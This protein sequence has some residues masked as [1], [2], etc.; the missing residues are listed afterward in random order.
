MPRFCN[1]STASKCF[2]Y[3]GKYIRVTSPYTLTENGNYR[4][5]Y[6]KTECLPVL[7]NVV[8]VSCVQ[9]NT[10]SQGSLIINEFSQGCQ[11]VEE[12]IELI[13]TGSTPFVTVEGMIIDD[14]NHSIFEQ[15]NESGHIRLGSCFSYV[16]VG[17]IILIYNGSNANPSINT[18][19]N[20]SPGTSGV[21]Q[22][23]VNDPCILHYPS[24]PDNH[25]T[26]RL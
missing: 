3:L 9:T 1:I 22:M 18:G 19:S 21:Y 12:Y 5:M 14:N 25:R 8:S 4:L 7:S 10:V 6:S 11:G 15:G 17:S 2:K 20:G 23:P 26:Y 16:P 13:V 24:C